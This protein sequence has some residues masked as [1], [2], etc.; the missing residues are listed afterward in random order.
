MLRT[1]ETIQ[2]QYEELAPLFTWGKNG[3]SEPFDIVATQFKQHTNALIQLTQESDLYDA[4]DGSEFAPSYALVM[5]T[6]LRPDEAIEGLL[7]LLGTEHQA[8]FEQ[9]SFFYGKV[10]GKSI[11]PLKEIILNREQSIEV[12]A[13]AIA[14]IFQ[15]GDQ[16]TSRSDEVMELFIDFL[17]RSEADEDEN[18]E[19]LNSIVIYEFTSRGA[20]QTYEVIQSAFR[21]NRVDTTLITLKDV[22]L[23]FGLKEEQKPKNELA[24]RCKLCNR[25]R[26]YE[27]KDA[28]YDPRLEADA[29]FPS[30][31]GPLFIPQT[32]TCS[33]CKAVDQY[34]LCAASYQKIVEQV[35]PSG[36]IKQPR[37]TF[38]HL[39]HFEGMDTPMHPKDALKAYKEQFEKNPNDVENIVSYANVSNL[40]EKKKQ[41]FDLFCQVLE[42]APKHVEAH[43]HLAIH[44]QKEGSDREA[45]TLFQKTLTLLEEFPNANSGKQ[46]ELENLT[47]FHLEGLLQDKD[48]IQ[49]VQ[50][51]QKVRRNDPCGCGS[52]KKY[53][54]CCLRNNKSEE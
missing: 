13:H 35:D 53:K 47:R 52:G 40:N 11:E 39:R 51:N 10:G 37:K 49:T 25:Q 44:A 48:Q 1:I 15:A 50:K 33:K 18:E 17:G 3:P 34:E 46:K 8:L 30:P 23:T 29:E 32:L 14:S 36:S 19:K 27:I 38:I 16:A 43:L 7:P 41:A 12:R 45:I 54:Q 31:H 24:L 22:K 26:L 6:V 20:T 42:L 28:Y 4:K 2:S 5:L 21:K 9:L